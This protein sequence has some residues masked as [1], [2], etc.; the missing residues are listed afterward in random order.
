MALCN[1]VEDPFT[2]IPKNSLGL[3]FSLTHVNRMTYP[4]MFL[5]AVKNSKKNQ[6][7]PNVHKDTSINMDIYQKPML[8]STRQITSLERLWRKGNPHSLLVGMQTGTATV[9]ECLEIPQKSKNRVTI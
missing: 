1:K 8:L 6:K 4:R 3:E 7:Y 9:E 2:P 5:T